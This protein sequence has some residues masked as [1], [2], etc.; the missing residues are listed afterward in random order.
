MKE[1]NEYIQNVMNELAHQWRQPL[2]HINSIVFSIDSILYENGIQNKEVEKKL[3]EIENITNHMSKTIDDLK[4]KSMD[5]DD[6]VF[7]IDVFDEITTLISSRLEKES[8]KLFID[9]DTSIS[10]TSNKRTLLQG[11]INILNNS[12]D[13]L[14]ERNIFNAYIKITTSK[15]E[16]GIIIKIIDNGGGITENTMRK[17]FD[18]DYTTKH[19]T[20]GSGVGLHMTK[21]LIEKH[22]QGSLNVYNMDYGVCF[23]IS[24]LRSR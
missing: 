11:I 18:K 7:L 21:E 13:A 10:I 19:T 3:K 2:S 8:I 23:E 15:T 20:E 22:L 5:N 24:L 6:T 1:D 17:I 16:K 4:N 9:V 12:I 14:L